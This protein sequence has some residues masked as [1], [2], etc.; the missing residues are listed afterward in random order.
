M[1]QDDETWMVWAQ[2]EEK[3][4]QLSYVQ[5]RFRELSII[6][7]PSLFVFV[8]LALLRAD[9]EEEERRLKGWKD[10]MTEREL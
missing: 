5:S 9:E 10:E 8:F 4:G 3:I 1:L 7:S 6:G 2:G